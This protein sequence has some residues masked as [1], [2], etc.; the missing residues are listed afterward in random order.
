MSL[1]SW[2]REYD[3]RLCVAAVAVG[4]LGGC[5]D[6]SLD[7]NA[8][9][10]DAGGASGNASSAGSGSIGLGGELMGDGTVSAAR[11]SGPELKCRKVDCPADSSPSTTSVSGIV[12]DPA[13][14]VPLYNAVVYV[15]EN[16][17]TDL[18]ALSERVACEACAAHFPQKNVLA[19][20][21]TDAKGSFRV[22]DMPTGDGVELVIQLG[23]WRRVVTLPKLEPCTDTR[24]DADLTRLPRHSGEGHLPKIAVT[25]G[26]SDALECLLKKIGIDP[27]EFTPGTADGR[28]NLFRGFEAA[29]G[30][31]SR[32]QSVQLTPAEELWA[33]ADRMLDYDM[34]VMSCEGDDNLW[35][36]GETLRPPEM[37]LELRK[38]ADLGGRVF[39][40][41][42]HHR[43]INSDNVTPDDPY[44]E[45]ANFAE[46]AGPARS[47]P[48]GT[49]GDV[50]VLVDT[51]FPKGVA[52]QDWLYNVG[53]SPT[54]GE[55]P[56]FEAEHTVD[57]LVAGVAQRWIYGTDAHESHNADMVQYFS[58]TTPV[59]AP[60]CG[61]MVFS[62]VHVS[63]GGDPY[64]LLPFPERCDA[65]SPGD[66]LSP[67]EKALE[68]MLFDL[69][70]C[71][72][73]ETDE[74]PMPIETIVK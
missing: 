52:F 16:P 40:S 9:G 73:K 27:D 6:E 66:E 17:E 7:G 48:A 53:A 56:L 54:L 2:F 30:M 12:Y 29:T 24:L 72:Q 21:L 8:G 42:W 69:S 38:Y 67:Q 5:G 36:P 23:K 26:A 1:E 63:F 60:E 71:I 19:V 59:G 41:H 62:D 39:G 15:V 46:A 31:I 10:A 58:F 68:F 20:A 51:T 61:R 33:D 65:A 70:S 45:V 64:N 50:T 43:W 18:P 35:N 11:C 57:S 55:L 34:V 4:L 37:H 3:A 44:P 22:T 25:T 32:G 49:D 47:T 28:V 14:R 74:V 13:G